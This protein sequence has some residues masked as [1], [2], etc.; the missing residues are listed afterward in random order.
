ML[1][2]VLPNGPTAQFKVSNVLLG[3]EIYN[4]GVK[5]D[6]LPEIVLNNFST[7]LGHRVGRFLGSLFPHRPEF[8][9]RTVCTF[10]NQRDFVFV[11]HHRYAFTEKMDRANLQ[12]VCHALLRT[13]ALTPSCV[14]FLCSWAQALR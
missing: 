13:A 8:E 12:E 10:H 14:F 4:H 5:T 3:K 1:L 11:R 6:H 9:G 2:S 7:R